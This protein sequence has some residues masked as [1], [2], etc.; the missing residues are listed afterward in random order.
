MENVDRFEDLP[1]DL[2]SRRKLHLLILLS[3][4]TQVRLFHLTS[5]VSDLKIF[6][7]EISVEQKYKVWRTFD[8]NLKKF[9]V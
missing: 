5:S 6:V 4:K 8:V 1:F 2:N 9:K 7:S 3:A